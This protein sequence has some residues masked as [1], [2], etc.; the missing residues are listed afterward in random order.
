MI[1]KNVSTVA[2]LYAAINDPANDGVTIVLAPGPYVLSAA[3]PGAGPTAG[4]LDLRKN[5]SLIGVTG[6]RSAVVIDAHLLPKASFDISFAPVPGIQK[7]GVMQDWE[8]QPF[9][10]MADHH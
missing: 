3:A 9:D 1:R 6:D 8:G 5:M 7:T 2:Q 4:R 10:R